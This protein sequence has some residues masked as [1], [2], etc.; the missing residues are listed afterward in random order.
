LLENFIKTTERENRRREIFVRSNI[1][2]FCTK[3]MKSRKMLKMKIK[4]IPGGSS[5]KTH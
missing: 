1:Q 2:Q 4:R 3:I 5:V